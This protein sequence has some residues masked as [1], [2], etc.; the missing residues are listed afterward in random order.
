MPW[1]AW[2]RGLWEERF[3]RLA[4]YLKRLQQGSGKS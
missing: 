4:A 3:N 1:I 2:Y